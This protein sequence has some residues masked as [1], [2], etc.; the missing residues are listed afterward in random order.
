[1]KL[2]DAGLQNLKRMHDVFRMGCHIFIVPVSITSFGRVSDAKTGTFFQ[3]RH[4]SAVGVGI[5]LS[6]T[7]QIDSC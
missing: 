1:M 2:L 5:E 4:G 3:L 7:L 6:N